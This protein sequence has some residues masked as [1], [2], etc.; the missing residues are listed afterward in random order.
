MTSLPS[1]KVLVIDTETTGL[2]KGK[3]VYAENQPW[4]VQI[5]IILMDLSK[6]TFDHS[7]NHLVIPPE[8]TF[9]NPKAVEVHGLTEDIVRANGEDMLGVMEML[10]DLRKRADI[11]A[12]YNLP[13]DERI[14]RS[15]SVRLDSS[16]EKDH[17]LGVH[18]DAIAHHCIMEYATNFFETR[19]RK[20][21]GQVVASSTERRPLRMMH[22]KLVTVYEELKGVKLEGAHDALA[23]AVAAAVVM[24]E[25]IYREMSEEN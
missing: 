4:P 3:D 13:F 19:R 18:G 8:G 15:S 9:F 14:I 11:V 10:R 25:L 21:V 24:K 7:S 20:S 5:G 16:F 17:V 12:A 1:L 6:D 23:D 22:R 2:P